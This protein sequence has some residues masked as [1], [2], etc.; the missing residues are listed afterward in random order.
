MNTG[1]NGTFSEANNNFDNSQ[2]TENENIR[3]SQE[4]AAES[5]DSDTVEFHNVR[6]NEE[7]EVVEIVFS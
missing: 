4:M 6:A 7:E 1:R 3:L 5:I 2:I